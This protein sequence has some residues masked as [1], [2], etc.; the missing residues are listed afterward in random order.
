LENPVLS[1]RATMADKRWELLL[2]GQLQGV[3]FRP[4]VWHLAKL[5]DLSGMIR[6]RSQGV[7]IE[8]QGTADRLE[9]FLSRL[10]RGLPDHARIDSILMEEIQTELPSE[11]GSSSF[12]I[13]P[14]LALSPLMVD[15]L[16]DLA[17]CEDCL[18]ELT[19]V[20]NR[21]YLYPF[22]SCTKCGPRYSIQRS[23]PFDRQ[24]TTLG[25]F[26]LCEACQLEYTNPE[27]RRFHAQTIGCFGCGPRWSW[28]ESHSAQI[29]CMDAQSVGL[30]LERC[31]VVLQTGGIVL[32]K[33]VG[34]YQ[35]IC[36]TANQQAT[37]RLRQLKRRDQKPFAVLVESVQVAL[38][39]VRLT[40][41]A[42]DALQA[43]HRPIVVGYRSSIE[44]NPKYGDW[45]SQLNCSLGVMLPNSPIQ[46]LIAGRFGSPLIVTSAN[47]SGEPMLIDDQQAMLQFG[48]KVAAVLL[49]DRQIVQ[50]LDD[51]LIRDTGCGVIPIR[52]G[53]GN[54][55]LRM[56]SVRQDASSRPAIALG[57]DLKAAW[58]ISTSDAVYL[59]QH[60]GD[61]SDPQVRSQ[62][63]KSVEKLLQDTGPIHA[64]VVDH[65]PGYQTTQLGE[66][67]AKD[68]SG[69]NA[70]ILCHHEQ[71]HVAHL[72]SLAVDS[73]ID[74]LEPMLGFVM[75]GSGYGFD[76]T[77]WGGELLS[78][79]A[80]RYSRLGHMRSVRMP[81]G[82]V[83]ARNPWRSALAMLL[84]AQVPI[85]AHAGLS[86]WMK[87]S[88]WSELSQEEKS[89][90]ISSASCMAT[91]VALTIPSSS[92]GRFLD[93]VA[94]LIGLVHCNQY[95]G[96]AAMLLEDRA[97]EYYLHRFQE[98]G[99][100]ID[101]MS[102]LGAYRFT[103]SDQQG[104]LEFDTRQVVRSIVEDLRNQI[105]LQQIA[106]RV[107]ASIA[108]LMVDM[109][110][111]LEPR[112]N[113]TRQVGL[114]GG[115]FQN[116][117]LVEL[118]TEF[119]GK[120]RWRVLLHHRIPPND[121]GIAVGQLRLG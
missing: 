32:V 10:H 72:K 34:G 102:D 13:A 113:C 44:G 77:I 38:Q 6:N 74:P 83:A 24:R 90:L 54:V 88:P 85:E 65:H 16:G 118:A 21:R 47:G 43:S 107:H 92:I 28:I 39:L 56:K 3:G 33:G 97:T 30:M 67:L 100:P 80:E 61:A 82:D 46:H 25:N 69:P 63:Q 75:D 93:A 117:L 96:H 120:S 7:S 87:A 70:Q 104:V 114:T 31:Q 26:A 89:L 105:A 73:Q 51:P 66:R 15:A 60:L 53:R 4:Y 11:D 12:E 22:I 9:E 17:P 64:L 18:S 112:W 29:D 45:L 71:H 62:I 58:A 99:F 111:R 49:H 57:A 48:S 115:V 98:N 103:I 94:S 55:P 14:S 108:S 116:R 19:D 36:D 78:I 52:L 37:T 1:D 81:I 106:F 84:D 8:I 68:C 23:S 41:D 59:M 5:L 109:L 91:S 110:E 86:H 27:N 76:G 101:S 2:S 95:E 40:P 42:L 121:S 35:F 50:S 79:H 119:I 20:E